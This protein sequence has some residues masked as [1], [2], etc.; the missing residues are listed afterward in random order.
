MEITAFESIPS[1]VF[2]GSVP[3]QLKTVM[4][5]GTVSAEKLQLSTFLQWDLHM[6]LPGSCLGFLSLFHSS[7]LFLKGWTVRVTAANRKNILAII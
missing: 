1:E 2:T 3:E 6:L 7:L 5:S 4:T